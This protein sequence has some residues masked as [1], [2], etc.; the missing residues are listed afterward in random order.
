[1]LL[2]GCAFQP[3]HHRIQTQKAF[4]RHTRLVAC[5]PELKTGVQHS[6]KP[7]FPR[8]QAAALTRIRRPTGPDDQQQTYE[9]TCTTETR[10][11]RAVPLELSCLQFESSANNNANIPSDPGHRR[12]IPVPCRRRLRTAEITDGK[13]FFKHF[14]LNVQ[15]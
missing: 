12:K 11:Q 15:L 13:S 7:L 5:A 6:G 4:Q 3:V 14:P 10:N 8:S 9:S 1:M 2:S